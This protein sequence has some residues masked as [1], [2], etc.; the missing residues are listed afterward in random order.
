MH[1]RQ[2]VPSSA[3]TLLFYSYDTPKFVFLDE[4]VDLFVLFDR[5]VH[6]NNNDSPIFVIII[7]VTRHTIPSPDPTFIAFAHTHYNR[8]DILVVLYHVFL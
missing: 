7:L 3:V 5:F 8:C 1:P 2:T 4:I 6:N